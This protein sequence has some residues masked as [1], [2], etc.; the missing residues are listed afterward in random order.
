M[1]KIS[2]NDFKQLV[3]FIDDARIK[4]P[5]VDS[6]TITIA[7]NVLVKSKS[8]AVVAEMFDISRQR[9]NRIVKNFEKSYVKM[10]NMKEDSVCFSICVPKSQVSE[11]KAKMKQ[12]IT[13]DMG[14]SLG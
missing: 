5:V 10:N 3:K 6:T 4:G 8:Q 14:L 7:Q 2:E 12:I 1:L 9:V 13:S 11:F